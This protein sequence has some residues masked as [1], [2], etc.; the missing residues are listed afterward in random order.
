[1]PS[2]SC[3]TMD[4]PLFSVQSVARRAG[5]SAHTIRAWEKRYRAVRPARSR[6]GQRRYTEADVQRLILLGRATN[7]GH[8]IGTIAQLPDPQLRRLLNRDA[9]RGGKSS[10][11]AALDEEFRTECISAVEA[12]NEP[13]LVGALEKALVRFGQQGL[14]RRIV[15]PLAEQIGELWRHGELTAAHEHFFT[16]T[17]RTF[18]GTLAQQFAISADAPVLVAAT[19]AGQYHELGAFMAAVAATYLGWR[20]VYLGS[21]LPAAE[22]AAAVI[23]VGAPVLVLSIIYPGDD[24]KLPNE[25]QAIRKRLPDTILIVGGRVARSY[26]AVLKRINARIVDDIAE[27]GDELDKI[28]AGGRK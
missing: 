11:A 15:A 1:M 5:L 19:P 16:A 27:L 18:I 10:S 9:E 14:L 24:G 21:S 17:A 12:M 8:A 28:R 4:H 6:A 7:A 3:P 22:V 25:L 13:A 23:Q 26:G 2:N 20:G